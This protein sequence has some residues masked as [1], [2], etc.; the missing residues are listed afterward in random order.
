MWVC[1]IHE[2]AIYTAKYG[3]N[4]SHSQNNKARKKEMKGIQ[5]VKEEAKLSICS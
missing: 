4:R 5:I 1:I 2:S 3:S